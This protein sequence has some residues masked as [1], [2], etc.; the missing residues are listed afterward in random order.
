LPIETYKPS[1]YRIIFN[2]N[3]PT[4]IK[5]KISTQIMR[6]AIIS[7][8]SFTVA[9]CK[10]SSDNEPDGAGVLSCLLTLFILCRDSPENAPGE[11]DYVS[12]AGDS[13]IPASIIQE[14]IDTA[15]DGDTVLVAP[16]T[17]LGSI[18]FR[19]KAIKLVSEQGPL[20][21]IIDGG[22]VDSPV[23]SF[24][25]AE[26]PES[27]LQ[28]FTIQ[29]GHDQGI[30]VRNASPGI[31]NNIVANT[32]ICDGAGIELNASSAIVRQNTLRDNLA[33]CTGNRAAGAILVRDSGSAVIVNNYIVGNS[34]LDLAGGITLW[35]AG[36]SIVEGNTITGNSGGAIKI[37]ES[38]D[39]LIL[40]NL[41]VNN[42]DEDCGGIDWLVPSS[43]TGPRVIN[44]TIADN[45]GALGSAICADGFDQQA[46]LINNIIV[47]KPGQTAIFCG[48]SQHA[49]F[50]PPL[51]RFNNVFAPSGVAYN[52]VC[53]NQT[54]INGNIS[55]DPL[56]MD[57]SNQDY[58]LSLNSP[59]I[60]AGDN[61]V[62]DLPLTDITG[63]SRIVDGYLN[64]I[65]VV[66]LGAY[67]F[68]P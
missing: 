39:A 35:D 55:A 8:L 22:R 33:T 59:A 66:D 37:R 58:Q 15:N 36:T 28:G 45:D 62:A 53:T 61:S 56:F 34:S 32:R 3:A 26:G 2:C 48:N 9:S 43:S 52:G 10:G 17:Y 7:I 18:D 46:Q 21:T 41:I 23:V 12:T 44:N 4:V 60:D 13:R 29:N 6:I 57:K 30:L 68:N 63:N 67:E 24:S 27:I 19:G 47:S 11:T 38:S 49:D 51:I 20:V 50:I 16:G 1:V 31:I 14:R 25:S 5:M 40:Q 54:S 65:A 64:T 42:T